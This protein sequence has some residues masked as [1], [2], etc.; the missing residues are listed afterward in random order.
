MKDT[1]WEQLG[2]NLQVEERMSM[3]AA[4]SSVTSSSGRLQNVRFTFGDI[5]IYLQVQV[6]SNPPYDVL[7]GRPF[8]TLTECVTKDFV[9][10]DQHIT[11]RDPNSGRLVTIP[12]R[13]RK[14]NRRPDPDF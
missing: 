1:I 2:N 3:E 9:D 10:G 7:L 13:E 12:T 6:M 11:I 8:T 14:R 4:N 5:D